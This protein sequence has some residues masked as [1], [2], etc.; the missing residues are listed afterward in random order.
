[1]AAAPTLDRNTVYWIEDPAGV[2]LPLI[3]GDVEYR[4]DARE[5]CFYDTQRPHALPARFVSGDERRGL[6]FEGPERKMVLRRLDRA[7]FD[8]VFRPAIPDAPRFTSDDELQAFYRDLIRQ[9]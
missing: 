1:M 8:R 4:A 2:H 5:L 9:M 6:T 7:S 3:A